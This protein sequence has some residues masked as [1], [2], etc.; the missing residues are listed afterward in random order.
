[1]N[2]SIITI[3]YNN[4]GGLEKTISSVMAQ[5]WRNFEWIIID[6][7]STDGSKE[8]IAELAKRTDANISYWCSER[9]KGVYNA[10]NKGVEYAKGEYLNF[11][12]SGDIFYSPN[13]LGMVFSHEHTAD[14]IYGDW[15]QVYKDH[16]KLMQAPND[17]DIRCLYHENICQQAMFVKKT[18][19]K[20]KGFDESYQ[21]WADYKRWVD[22]AFDGATFEH[23]GFTVCLYDAYGISNTLLD[24]VSIEDKRLKATFPSAVVKTITKYDGILKSPYVK[25]ILKIEKQGGIKLLL[26]RI[27]F[28]ILNA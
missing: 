13:T 28:K 27:V 1:M 26:L 2:L 19:L 18:L 20:N 14:I 16:E 12:N 25:K 23:L 7:G 6:G 24:I 15:L 22:A 3:N 4:K 9:D 10:M 5:T 11:M 17:I 8:V 21:L